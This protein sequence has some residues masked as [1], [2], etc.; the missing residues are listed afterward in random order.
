MSRAI[1]TIDRRLL[2]LLQANARESAATLGRKLGIAR[3]TVQERILRLQRNGII[4]S[5]SVVLRQDP[6]ENYAELILMITVAHRRQK[7]VIEQLREFPEIKLCQSISGEFDMIC[8]ARVVQLEDAQPVVDA[9]SD[10]PGV[11]RVKSIVVLATN[12]DRSPAEIASL[13][14]MQSAAWGKGEAG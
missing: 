7:A 1:D 2:A 13:A 10:I 9:V 6:T 5:Y 4:S 14:S 8:R 12:F 3:T 11:E